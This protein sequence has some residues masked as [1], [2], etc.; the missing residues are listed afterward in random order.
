M[1][2]NPTPGPAD[3][4]AW[5][6]HAQQQGGPY[7]PGAYL[8]PP[9]YQPP[10]PAR[11]AGPVRPRLLWIFLS[12]ALFLV[13]LIVGI[14]G[15]AGNLVSTINDSAPTTT[16]GSGKTVSVELDAKDKPAIY[17]AADQP[18]DVQCQVGDG[19][20]PRIK[21]TQPAGSQVVTVD[22]TKW[23]LLFKVDVPEAGT[24]Q[25][26]CEGAGVTFGVGRELAA[27]TDKL[28]G[29]V[30]ALVALPVIGFL[31]AL[32]VTTVVLVR[33]SSARR[34]LAR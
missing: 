14:V 27:E 26:T 7:G 23:E 17:A 19:Q 5:P 3:P 13:L 18:T 1:N 24:Y 31:I 8:P 20:D 15:F 11:P 4:T 21:L 32:V 6:P 16:F 30:I 34:N 12:W 22:G 2:Q 9:G 33:R 25:V 28:V 29:G 10:G